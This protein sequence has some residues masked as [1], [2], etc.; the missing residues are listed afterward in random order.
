MIGASLRNTA[1]PT[2]LE[3]GYKL[4]VIPGEAVAYVDGRFVPGAQ[5]EFLATIDELIGDKVVREMVNLDVAP[6]AEFAGELVEAMKASL[7]AEDSAARPI[8]YLMSGGTDGKAWSRLGIR[9][10]GFAPLKLP[11]DLDFVGMFHGVDERVPT[12]ALE[13][14]ARVLDRFLDQV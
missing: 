5:E 1:N 14:G 7:V 3:A 9:S 8:P 4:N 2:M 11:A 10:Y 12:D 6:E 13:F